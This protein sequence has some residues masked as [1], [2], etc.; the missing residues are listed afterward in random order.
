MPYEELREKGLIEDVVPNLVLVS[1]L[2]NRALKDLATARTNGSIDREWAY[3]IAFQGMLR[4]S[5]GMIAAEGLRPR[6]RDQQRTVA[7][8]AGTILVEDA[9]PLVNAFDRMRRRWQAILDDGGQ[10]VSRYEAE[11]AIKEAQRFIERTVEW[12]RT[13]YPQL[14]V[15]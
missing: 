12:T 5:K 8:L 15:P 13:R 6:G 3:I 1:Q 7:V 9:K 11:G 14:I 4:A 2:I 10:P